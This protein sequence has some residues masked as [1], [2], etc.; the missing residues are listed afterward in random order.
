MEKQQD[1]YRTRK[2]KDGDR[3]GG[4]TVDPRLEELRRE[5]RRKIISST[6]V[7]VV[8]LALVW[9]YVA[10]QEAKEEARKKLAPPVTST[11]LSG[12]ASAEQGAGPLTAQPDFQDFAEAMGD[13][14]VRHLSEQDRQKIAEAMTQVRQAYKYMESREWDG[15]ERHGLEALKLWPDMN[16]AMRLLGFV[17]TQRGQFDQAIAILQKSLET[18]PFSAE[19]FN[20]LATAHMQKWEL[21]MAEDLLHT[22]LEIN[23]DYVV[24]HINIGLLHL[25]NGRYELAADHLQRALEISPDMVNVRNN[26]AVAM[27]RLGRYDEARRQ[28]DTIMR[29][30]PG[31]ASA[32]FNMAITYVQERNADEALLWL[33]RGAKLCS[34]VVCRNYLADTDFDPIRNHP[35]F[36]ALIENLYP[37]L[38]KLPEG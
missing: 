5:N 10:R 37:E 7:M 21:S 34:P 28:L 19:T 2:S 36:Q 6:T 13:T 17:Y 1:I 32:Y 4:V 23:P 11:D 26:L 14:R 18:E 29:E 38:P 25:I 8:C 35:G 31:R 30:M 33:H 16:A 20:N 9:W 15:A 12:P 22:A 27:I 3:V 24:S